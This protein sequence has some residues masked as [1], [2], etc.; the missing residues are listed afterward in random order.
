MAL[1]NIVVSDPNRVSAATDNADGCYLQRAHCPCCGASVTQARRKA[2]SSPPAET[3][4]LAS[5]GRFLSGYTNQRVFFTYFQCNRC[6]AQFCPIYYTQSQLDRLYSR[7]AENMADVPLEARRRTQADYARL[8]KRYSRM[9]GSFLEIGADIGLF[10]QYCAEHGEFEH[11]WLYEPNCDV[12]AK[13]AD[14]FRGRSFTIGEKKFRG[15]DVPASSLSTAVLIHVLD[16]L[17]DPRSL[18]QDIAASMEQGGILFVVTHDCASLLARLLGSRWPPYTL[19]HPLLFSPNSVSRLLE[20]CGFEVVEVVKSYNYFPA[21][22]FA[23]AACAILGLPASWLPTWQ[24]PLIGVKLGN[25]ATVARK[26]G[27]R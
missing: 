12:H 15:A 9:S 11:F 27:R 21:F 7:Q 22:H 19:Q 13:L 26:I 23:R 14:N 8:L 4:D 1:D 2:A 24:M 18:L 20:S 5:H 10:A 17:L 3:L 25:I 16:H 6:G